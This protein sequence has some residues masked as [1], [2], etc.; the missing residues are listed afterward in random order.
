MRE[1]TLIASSSTVIMA[2]ATSNVFHCCGFR[3][4]PESSFYF[5][6]RTGHDGTLEPPNCSSCF[7]V[8]PQQVTTG[9][10]YYCIHKSATLVPISLA[11]RLIGVVPAKYLYLAPVLLQWGCERDAASHNSSE[12]SR[13]SG[14][15]FRVCIFIP[16]S[17]PRL[18]THTTTRAKK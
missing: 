2:P 17:W 5:P 8:V 18:E 14:V 10:G 13:A 16:L 11:F 9:A 15:R 12:S 6:A 1:G 4:A 3:V 7:Y